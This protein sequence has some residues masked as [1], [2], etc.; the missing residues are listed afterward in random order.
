VIPAAL[1]STMRIVVFCHSLISDW[2]HGNAHFLRGVVAELL[3]R[4]HDVA[5]YEP[6][7]SWSRTNLLADAGPAGV[8]RFRAAFPAM[9]ST[10][11]DYDRIDLDR[12]LDG[13]DVVL[14]H[15]WT[16]HTLVAAI[17]RHHAHGGSYLLLF[18]DTHHRSVT[19]VEAMQ[20]YALESYDG[21]LAFGEVI[22]ERY[23]SLGWARQ[24]WTWHE[25]A[26]TRIFRPHPDAVPSRDLVWIGNWGDDERSTELRSYLIEPVRDLGLTATVHGVRY[27]A[28][29]TAEL[30][31][32]GAAFGG[33]LPNHDAPAAYARHRMT[34]HIPR[35]PYVESLPGI[36]TI[37]VFEALA[38]GVPLVSTEWRDVE[39]LFRAGEDF[40]VA[41][42]PDQM[43]A[44]LAALRADAALRTELSAHGLA[45]IRERHTCAHRVDQLLGIVGQQRAAA[46]E[47]LIV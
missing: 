30:A 20:R 38:C 25:A 28:T 44:H 18:H 22:R 24:A 36:P 40:L 11:V 31:G 3:D 13:A 32:A 2:N 37:R 47:V 23:V 27:P 8:S 12:V 26:D 39:G 1:P 34:V 35:R 46:T 45:T 16:P 19:D 15:E 9:T 33:W 43:R 6:L 10:I 14:V 42:T 7:D 41:K 21:V 17:G 5:V 4:G 29:A